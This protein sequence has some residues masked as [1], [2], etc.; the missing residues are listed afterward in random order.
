MKFKDYINEDAPEKYVYFGHPRLYYNT[1]WEN[2][3]IQMIQKK[4]PEFI[5]M[6]PN[7]RQRFEKSVKKMGFKIF[8]ILVDKC[9]FGVFMLLEDGRWGGG[10]YKEASR[11]ESQGKPIYEINPWKNYIK[12]TTTKGVTPIGK[13]DPYYK[14]FTYDE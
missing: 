13:D 12:K 7:Q 3:C 1:K 11:M 6:N 5:I 9:E 4:W 2:K 8:N 14:K 10:I